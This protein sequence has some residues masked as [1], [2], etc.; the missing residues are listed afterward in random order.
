MADVSVVLGI[1][2]HPKGSPLMYQLTLL[3][4]CP[5]NPFC[6]VHK[7]LDSRCSVYCPQE[8]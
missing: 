1:K 6:K 8:R 3:S 7:V 4:W 2:S 5:W